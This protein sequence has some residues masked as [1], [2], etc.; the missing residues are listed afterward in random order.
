MVSLPANLYKNIT[1]LFIYD[2]F[3]FQYNRFQLQDVSF[4]YVNPLI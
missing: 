4:C 1:Y 2:V 3:L